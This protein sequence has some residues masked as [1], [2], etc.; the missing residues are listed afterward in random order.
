M[1]FRAAAVNGKQSIYLGRNNTQNTKTQDKKNR[2]Q[3][4]KNK[5]KTNKLKKHKTTN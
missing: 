4:H 5:Q 1:G 3:K 2:K